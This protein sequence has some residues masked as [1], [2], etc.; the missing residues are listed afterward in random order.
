MP[1]VTG[2]GCS[3]SALLGAFHAVDKDPVSAAATGLAFLSVAGET[4]GQEAKGPGSF[5][6]HLLDALYNLSPSE[7]ESR[8]RIEKI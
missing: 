1:Y 8:S 3:A 5:M 7:V 4:A 6:M 2:T